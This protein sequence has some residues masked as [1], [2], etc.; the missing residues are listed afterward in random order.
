M[1]VAKVSPEY[2]GF[3]SETYEVELQAGAH[4]T[5]TSCSCGGWKVTPCLKAHAG[6]KKGVSRRGVAFKDRR[7][8]SM[9]SVSERS[10]L[11]RRGQLVRSSVAYPIPEVAAGGSEATRHLP[12]IF[13]GV[14]AHH[15]KLVTN[16]VYQSAMPHQGS[17]AP[18]AA[19]WQ[20][21]PGQSQFI[22]TSVHTP[23]C[24]KS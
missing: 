2:V 9:L 8:E 16:A 20:S 19:T 10:G 12:A 1:D 3:S 6:A 14:N 18:Y 7:A 22:S 17:F 5:L 23:C 13:P 11:Q 24:T 21:V 15:K 4:G